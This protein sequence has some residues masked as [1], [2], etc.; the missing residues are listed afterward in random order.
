MDKIY[1]LGFRGNIHTLLKSYLTNRTQY[2]ELDRYRSNNKVISHGVPQGSV[3]GPLLFNLFFNDV[4]YLKCDSRSLFANDG[5]FWLSDFSFDR[6]VFRLNL[7]LKELLNWLYSNKLYPN[8]S[9]TFLMLF[10]NRIV[11]NLP[12]VYLENDLLQWTNNI[13]YLGVI[14]DNKLNFNLQLHHI[15][16]KISKSSGIIYRLKTFLPKSLLLKIYNS[17]FYPYLI[18]NI[19]IWGGVSTNKLNPIQIQMNKTLRHILDVHFDINHRPFMS[20]NNMFKKLNLMKFN[21][22]FEYFMIKFIHSC[23]YGANFNIFEEHFA[24]LLPDHKYETRHKKMNFP[25]V[26][27]Q[28]ER[29]MTK[30]HFIRLFNDLPENFFIPQSAQTLKTKYK[31]HALQKY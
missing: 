17:L 28:S 5:V 22:I 19:I 13:K 26:R 4:V 23:I 31:K 14:I 7:F 8:S 29:V 24:E 3:L 18:Q 11:H 2:I 12:S 30:Y 15:H 21:E 9:K 27:L 10:T 6:L 16:N 25:I 1:K 20:T